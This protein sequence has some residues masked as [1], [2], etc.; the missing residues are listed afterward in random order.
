M[1]KS[2]KQQLRRLQIIQNAA[3][4][5]ILLCDARCSTF[6]LHGRLGWDTLSTRTAKALVRI[7]FGCLHNEQ[8]PYLFECLR[9]LHRPDR[10]TR[11][12]EANNLLVPR[13]KTNYGRNT[14]EYRASSQWNITKTEIKASVN[15]NQLKRLLKSSWYS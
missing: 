8:P 13:V 5:L 15:I 14:F 10:P 9:T 6:E 4:R 12:T 11:A 1:I 3:A 7:T 2:I